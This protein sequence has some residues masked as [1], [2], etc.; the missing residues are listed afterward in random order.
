MRVGSQCATGRWSAGRHIPGAQLAGWGQGQPCWGAEEGGRGQGAS[1][2]QDMSHVQA[3]PCVWDVHGLEL[4][5][6]SQGNIPTSLISPVMKIVDFTSA[7][8]SKKKQSK[9]M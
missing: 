1:G 7:R 6:S 8:R 4:L 3:G 9:L 5:K 2:G